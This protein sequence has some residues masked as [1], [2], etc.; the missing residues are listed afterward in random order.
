MRLGSEAGFQFRD[1]LIE[2]GR[3]FARDA[4]LEFGAM[5][6]GSKALEPRRMHGLRA[7]AE[8]APC[9]KH[10]SRNIERLGRQTE[11]RLGTGQFF[12]TER[13]AMGF[14]CAGAL[15]CAVADDGFTGNESRAVGR[16][17]GGDGCGNRIVI[18]TINAGCIPAGR[19]KAFQLINRV[20]NRERAVDGNAVIVP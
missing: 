17:R 6:G 5:R 1:C 9:V 4:A 8:I 18:V 15:W 19:F 16:L 20:G 2:T 14:R 11:G 10:I 3:Q 13:L 7:L 12:G